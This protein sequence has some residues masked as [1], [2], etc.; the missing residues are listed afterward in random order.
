MVRS[1]PGVA[2]LS[3][4][5]RTASRLI[6]CSAGSWL[7]Y[8]RTSKY[9]RIPV[10]LFTRPAPAMTISA[11]ITVEVIA[12][13]TAVLGDA[14]PPIAVTTTIGTGRWNDTLNVIEIAPKVLTWP[15]EC[16]RF[17]G[18]HE[19]GHV[20]QKPMGR[21]WILN[22][23]ATMLI[24]Y[25]AVLGIGLLRIGFTDDLLPFAI[26]T[27]C[28]VALLVTV[29]LEVVTSRS[30]RR[31]YRADR[32]AAAAVGVDGL[33]QWRRIVQRDLTASNRAMLALNGAMGFRTHPSWRRRVAASRR[34][35]KDTSS[36]S[37]R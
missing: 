22:T 15:P 3:A 12:G 36:V 21:R 31:E 30:R 34:A 24:T 10:D 27:T 17:V 35:T 4:T 37:P 14:T 25:I 20:T 33:I 18:S 16:Q 26:E 23:L 6:S 11:P 19:A 28:Y 5:R 7:E 29:L 13:A 2:T 9:A 1:A 8:V 32:V